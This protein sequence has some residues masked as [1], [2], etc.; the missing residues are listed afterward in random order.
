MQE[1]DEADMATKNPKKANLL[2]HHSIKHLLDESV[3]E[4][5]NDEVLVEGLSLKDV[6]GLVSDHTKE[7]KKSK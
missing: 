6:E 4:F 2:D 5:T 3:T 7:S 1:K